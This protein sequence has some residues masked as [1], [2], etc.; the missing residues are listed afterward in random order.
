MTKFILASASP[1]RAEL[2][3]QIG[4]PFTVQVSN[5]DEST[6]NEAEPAQLAAQLALYKGQAVAEKVDEGVI[7]AADTIV[8]I[9][10]ELLGKP[11][12]KQAA[13]E[14]LRRL[15]G[16]LHHVLT[17]VAV[18][19]KPA[20]LVRTHV[21]STA[22]YL[23]KLTEAEIDWYVN[24]EEPYD[25]AG[26][27]G[28]QGKAAVFIEKIE[29]CYFNVVGLPLAALWQLLMAAGIKLG[30]GAGEYDNSAPDHQGA[31]TK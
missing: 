5:V 6:I 24:T 15:S 16:K 3:R 20:G 28:I 10:G 30:E 31:A 8:N 2:L 19:S 7:I 23:R 27:Y 25:K 13:A 29:G 1:R 26:G 22:V 18:I 9:N 11:A 14:M 4:L 21:E 17:G 12:T